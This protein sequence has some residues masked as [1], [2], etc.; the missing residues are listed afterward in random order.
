[1]FVSALSFVNTSNFNLFKESKHK[2]KHINKSQSTL[3]I[4]NRKY[5]KKNEEKKKKEDIKSEIKT[6]QIKV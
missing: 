6:T 3:R 1:V 2:R 4:T 5:I